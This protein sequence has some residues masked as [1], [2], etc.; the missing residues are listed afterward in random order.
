MHDFYKGQGKSRPRPRTFP[1]TAHSS[2]YRTTPS[3]IN[4]NLPTSISRAGINY[5]RNSRLWRSCGGS[6]G[7]SAHVPRLRS[8]EICCLQHLFRCEQLSA[9]KSPPFP[10]HVQI[11]Q[12]YISTS[13]TIY[14]Y[15]GWHRIPERWKP[16]QPCA[17]DP[18]EVCDSCV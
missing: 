17:E 3:A 8:V 9:A 7:F 14:R 15:G 4:V 16:A 12:R 10:L 6:G 13:S 11:T 2:R 18:Q 1:Y 5:P